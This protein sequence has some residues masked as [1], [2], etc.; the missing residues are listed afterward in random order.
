MFNTGVGVVELRYTVSGCPFKYSVVI[1]DA[2]I[3]VTTNIHVYI[4]DVMFVSEI[5]A[6]DLA[7]LVNIKVFESEMH[8]E[9]PFHETG[10]IIS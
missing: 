2:S 4:N 6:L 1:P 8:S 7:G 10:S 5:S 3:V 9:I